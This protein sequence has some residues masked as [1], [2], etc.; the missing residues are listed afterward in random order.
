MVNRLCK[1]SK[2]NS[3][4]VFGARGVGKSTLLKNHFNIDNPENLYVDLLDPVLE[5]RYRLDADLLAREIDKRKDLRWVII[6]EIQ[7]APRLLDLVHKHIENSKTLFAMSGSSARK[8]KRG[9]ANLLAGRAFVYEL[10]PFSSFELG[11]DFNLSF[12][13]EWGL[14][15]KIF[16]YDNDQDRTEFLLSYSL[17]YIKEEIQVEQLIRKLQPFRL[18]LQVAAQN[19]GKLVNFS[20]IARQCGVD[21]TTIQNYYSILE[22][23]LLGFFLPAWHLS[24]RKRQ[25]QSPRF[26]FIDAGIARTLH[27]LTGSKLVP[28]TSAYGEA[29]ESF[30]ILEIKKMAAYLKKTWRLSYLLTKDDSE[31]DLIIERPGQ[32]TICLE[33]KSSQSISKDVLKSFVNLSRDIK[34]SRCMCLSNDQLPQQV[35]HVECLYWKDGIKEIFEM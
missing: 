5:D 12:A 21:T 31:I 2:S 26:F 14:L 16:S 11:S 35:E 1:L 3:F 22:D 28:H 29:F 8:L 24:V 10:Y 15:P 9:G 4:F 33:I 18:F 32:K 7:K 30:I 13:L 20:R 25:A 19:H 6:D 27:G 17:T 34:N 23:T